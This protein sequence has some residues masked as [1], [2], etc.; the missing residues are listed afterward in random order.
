[1]RRKDVLFGRSTEEIAIGPGSRYRHKRTPDHAHVYRL[2]DIQS[3]TWTNSCSTHF[4]LR[5]GGAPN[6]HFRSLAGAPSQGTNGFVTLLNQCPSSV[7]SKITEKQH[8]MAP[9]HFSQIPTCFSFNFSCIAFS[10]GQRP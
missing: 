1:M 6:G 10:S 4:E 2:E 3:H 9:A 7:C 8:S 5:R